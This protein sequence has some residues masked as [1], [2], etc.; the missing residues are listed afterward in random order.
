MA[1]SPPPPHVPTIP[2]AT[3]SLTE[4][5]C[6]PF[7]SHFNRLTA[8]YPPPPPNVPYCIQLIAHNPILLPAFALYGG[9][10]CRNYDLAYGAFFI[11]SWC[12]QR[13]KQKL[14]T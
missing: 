12:L 7:L 8:P 14:C 2:G 5:P 9:S 1:E 3:L 10:Q 4:N 6:A 11:I 13:S